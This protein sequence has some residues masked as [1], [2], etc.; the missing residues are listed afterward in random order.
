MHGLTQKQ[1]IF[2]A[3]VSEGLNFSAAYRRAYDAEDMAAP[4]V[5]RE[6]HHLSRQENVAKRITLLVNEKIEEER[7]QASM[8]W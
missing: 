1:E 8:M 3:L 4:S 6:A 2:A 7:L 5:W